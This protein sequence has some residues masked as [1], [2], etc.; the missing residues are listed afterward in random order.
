MP[1][2]NLPQDFFTVFLAGA[3]HFPVVHTKAEAKLT[4]KFKKDFSKVKYALTVRRYHPDHIIQAHLHRASAGDDGEVIA[5]LLKPHHHQHFHGHVSGKL[6]A[7]DLLGGVRTIAELYELIREG[8]VYADV[9]S[10]DR[11]LGLVRGQVFTSS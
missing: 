10:D 6:R 8:E 3:Q 1:E 5:F 4:L 7:S 9:H 11:P 2:P